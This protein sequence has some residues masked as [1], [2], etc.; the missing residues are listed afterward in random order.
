MKKFKSK[1]TTFTSSIIFMIGVLPLT[2]CS[3][4]K[5]EESVTEYKRSYSFNEIKNIEKNTFRKINDVTFPHSKNP[6][7][8]EL[9]D[10]EVN[11]YAN[12]SNNT[13]H[14]LVNSSN[15]KNISYATVGLYSL[16]NELV[17]ASSGEELTT[18][19]N[20]LLGL[21]STSRIAF[22]KKVMKANS[23]ANKENTTQLKNAAFFN[24]RYDY[25][26]DYVNT[27][28]KL[29]CQAFQLS[30][31][32]DVDKMVD[33]V[34]QAVNDSKFIDEKFLELS[35]DSE[36]YLFSTLYFKNMW[37]DKYLAQ[38]NVKDKFYL[39]NGSTISTTFMKH[40]YM[41][42]SYYDYGDYISVR[43][44]YDQG[45]ASITYLVPKK[46]KDNI[47]DLTKDVNFFLEDE[48]K[49]VKDESEFPNWFTVN[50]KTPKFKLKCDLNFK[51]SLSDLGFAK[52]FDEN[53]DS[54]KNAFNDEDL[55]GYNM[56]ISVMKQRN[57]VE[58]SEDGT[59]VKSVSMAGIS[60]SE[61]APFIDSKTLDIDLNQPFIYIIRDINDTP[62]FVGHV[63]NPDL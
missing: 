36:L 52:M 57:E 49:K 20:N 60:K 47:F 43:D 17:E 8:T 48:T 44:F 18:D 32:N 45:N 42:E 62:I 24:N 6:V 21:D 35:D 31:K 37:Q 41:V 5:E 30:F 40:S 15:Q 51:E 3:W 16:L 11:A 38:D 25:N 1:L 2:A 23:F 27:L 61:S 26:E 50:L 63:D 54:F 39:S 29:Y 12:F 28:T 59:I 56:Y 55:L 58:F 33:W 34:N 19:L 10:D 22:Y 53:Y 7:K 13:Y 4:F 9:T 46:T 14:A